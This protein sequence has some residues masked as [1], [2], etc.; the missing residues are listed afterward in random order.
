[1][2]SYN[3]KTGIQNDHYFWP[4]RKPLSKGPN[5][6]NTVCQVWWD[7]GCKGKMPT[8]LGIQKGWGV[9]NIKR[10]DQGKFHSGVILRMGGLLSLYGEQRLML[11]YKGGPALKITKCSKPLSLISGEV[12]GDI[13][14]SYMATL[15]YQ[16]R[17]PKKQ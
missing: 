16:L 13:Q 8:N 5:N 2:Q 4:L 3:V 15:Q 11:L 6:V 7:L 9:G 12:S 14:A 17:K 10:R 1:M